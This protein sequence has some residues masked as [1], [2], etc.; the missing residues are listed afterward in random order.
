MKAEHQAKLEAKRNEIASYTT[1]DIGMTRED[2]LTAYR[3]GLAG[4]EDKTGI[5]NAIK[6]LKLPARSNRKLQLYV[7]QRIES[8][9]STVGDKLHKATEGTEV[10]DLIRGLF[11]SGKYNFLQLPEEIE[12][13]A[14]TEQE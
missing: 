9:T 4:Q 8:P 10:L 12:A 14:Y 13:E 2:Y 6:T 1:V 7:E 5:L 3:E 11:Q